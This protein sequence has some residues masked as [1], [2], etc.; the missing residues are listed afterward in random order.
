MNL[1]LQQWE[2]NE[3]MSLFLEIVGLHGETNGRSCNVHALCGEHVAVGDV[4]RM[5]PCIVQHN[6]EDKN[7]VK[8]AKVVDGVD[9]CTVAFLPCHCMSLPKVLGHMNKFAQVAEI[10]SD[11]KN[12]HKRSKAMANSGVA[13]VTLLDDATMAEWHAK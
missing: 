3:N 1:L 12:A 10:H 2:D 6:R 13:S 8:F 9:A 11:S 5:V 4:L 7:A